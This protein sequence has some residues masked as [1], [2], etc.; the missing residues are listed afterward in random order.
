MK[1]DFVALAWL[2]KSKWQAGPSQSMAAYRLSRTSKILN[3][4]LITLIFELVHFF[5]GENRAETRSNV[6]LVS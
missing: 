1:I 5:G 4:H 6:V 2:K 3:H